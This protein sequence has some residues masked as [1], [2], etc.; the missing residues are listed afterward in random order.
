[1]TRSFLASIP[2]VPVL[3]ALGREADSRGRYWCPFHYD[4]RP[5]GK[6]SAEISDDP[7]LFHCW[8]CDRDATA[9]EVA[10][11]FLG[12]SVREATRWCLERVS[13]LENVAPRRKPEVSSARLESEYRR[14]TEGIRYPRDV[15]PVDSFL[16]TRP[17]VPT[18]GERPPGQPSYHEYV[19]REW[20]WRGDYHGR[21]VMPH[22]DA[23]GTMTGLK[24][25]IP[26]D[27]RKLHRPGSTFPAL[28]GSWRVG[29]PDHPRDTS[30]S[31]SVAYAPEVT[32]ESRAVNE[33]WVC[34]GETDTA[35]AGFWLEPLGV[36]V[37]GLVG[38]R[39]R[40]T[41]DMLNLLA[42]ERVVLCVD[43]VSKSPGS[44]A[45]ATWAEVL[46]GAGIEYRAL[47]LGSD[48]DLSKYPKTPI[49]L[50]GEITWS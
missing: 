49:E 8:S 16:W 25:R 9:P 5:G 13:P 27:W 22:R 26:P 4:E 31:H 43:D 45:L 6:P 38:A 33:T 32:R 42:G 35:Y 2:L 30:A 20:G 21:V 34:E 12:V 39:Q 44:E 15:D 11:E 29:G 1:M 3:F 41:D 7:T 18:A 28:Y 23:A 14:H 17:E 40:P 50:R 19:T 36:R 47:D 24:W 10:A 46:V 37:L 48:Y